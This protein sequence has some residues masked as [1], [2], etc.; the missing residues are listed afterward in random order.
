MGWQL[1]QLPGIL[2]TRGKPTGAAAGAAAPAA[3]PADL[4]ARAMAILGEETQ[5]WQQRAAPAAP[6]PHPA[7]QALLLRRHEVLR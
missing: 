4:V 3:A 5:A 2:D 1:P 7:A 6:T